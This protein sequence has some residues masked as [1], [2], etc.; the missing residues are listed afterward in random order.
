M[1]NDSKSSELPSLF[2]TSESSIEYLCDNVYEN[3][4]LV[5]KF[6]QLFSKPKKMKNTPSI[7]S[8]IIL[9]LFSQQKPATCQ[10]VSYKDRQGYRWFS[11]TEPGYGVGSL[12]EIKRGKIGSPIYTD[13]Y[14][15]N[16]SCMD[17]TRIEPEPVI[18]YKESYDKQLNSKNKIAALFRIQKD[19]KLTAII[20]RRQ[21]AVLNF[22]EGF[23]EVYSE[24]YAIFFEALKK[25]P[26][27]TIEARKVA[28][29]EASNRLFIITDAVTLSKGSL[30]I[31]LR[32]SLDLET[33]LNLNEKAKVESGTTVASSKSLQLFFEQPQV[34][35]F[36]EQKVSKKK[37]L[38]EINKTLQ[39]RK[40]NNDCTCST[41]IPPI[42][43][44][45]IIYLDFNSN[46]DNQSNT[47]ITID[48]N[49]KLFSF[50]VDRF[51]RRDGAIRFKNAVGTGLRINN[52][53]TIQKILF[54]PQ[55]SHTIS[56][57][58]K[59]ESPV[60]TYANVFAF[61]LP[62]AKKEERTDYVLRKSGQSNPPGIFSFFIHSDAK[63]RNVY[64]KG[65]FQKTGSLGQGDKEWHHYALVISNDLKSIEL[66]EDGKRLD[67]RQGWGTDYTPSKW[68]SPKHDKA[69]FIIG[70]SLNRKTRWTGLMDDFLWVN[71]ALTKSEVEA[72]AKKR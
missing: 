17:A 45:A 58:L 26:C 62:N 38:E 13:N 5:I 36:K 57:W 4:G 11:L 31:N 53:K 14:F 27:E 41:P 72:L 54:D 18:P 6:M 55:S 8:I 19:G 71:R 66:W 59:D 12:I 22:Q 69:E 64:S 39:I 48:A 52:N 3:T 30:E 51:G 32:D 9:I 33:Q 65:F 70:A 43:E 50:D 44:N 42:E 34:I 46:V 25:L 15:D 20:D 60:E 67:S 24:G 63:H 47:G 23:R 49:D 40:K 16:L 61:G 37:L 68:K 7:I 1:K 35:K 2:I 10:D 21:S 28:L 29:E 56:F